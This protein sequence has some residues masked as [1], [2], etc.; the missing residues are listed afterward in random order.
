MSVV[1]NVDLEKLFKSAIKIGILEKS[2]FEIE[3]LREA[4]K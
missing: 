4:L 3:N 1:S 2:C